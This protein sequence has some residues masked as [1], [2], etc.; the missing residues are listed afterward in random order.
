MPADRPRNEQLLEVFERHRTI[1]NYTADRIPEGDIARILQ[2]GRRAPTDATGFMY[3]VIRVTDTDLRLKLADRCGQ[4]EHIAQASDFFVICLDVHRQGRL[5]EALGE[6]PA[7]TGTW[8]LLFGVVDA[9]LVAQN[10]ATAAEALGYG[11]GF[12]GGVHYDTI[13][14]ARAL[15]LPAGVFPVVGL[16]VGVIEREPAMRKRLP[17]E[18][19]FHENAYAPLDEAGARACFE[20]MASATGTFDWSKTLLRYFAAG[21]IMEKRE[22]TIASALRELGILPPLRVD[23]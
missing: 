1:R 20:S 12:I 17:P 6:R 23:P 8:A 15:H 4:Q 19:T 13:G 10:M 18:V 14:V 3:T 16:T 5:I 11:T 7:R 22:P 21:G 9:V 2:A